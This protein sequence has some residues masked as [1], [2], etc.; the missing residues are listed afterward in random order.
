MKV[1]E[2]CPTEK[3]CPETMVKADIAKRVNTIF[4]SV[5]LR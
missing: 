2:W 4:I 5:K 3:F 1:A